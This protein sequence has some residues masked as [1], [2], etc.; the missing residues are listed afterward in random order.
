MGEKSYPPRIHQVIHQVIHQ[1]GRN[2]F[3]QIDRHLILSELIDYCCRP[4]FAFG[5]HGEGAYFIF[6][7]KKEDLLHFCFFAKKVIS[8]ATLS[9]H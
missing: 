3:V 7:E 4:V 6:N 1:T 8:V 5:K 9:P 2:L